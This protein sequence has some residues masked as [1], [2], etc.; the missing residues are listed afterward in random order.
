MSIRRGD[1]AF[2]KVKGVNFG[3]GAKSFEARV[4]SAADGR[5]HRAAPGQPDGTIGRD[6]HR[7][8]ARGAGRPGPPGPAKSA[9]PPGLHDLYLRFT[10]GSGHL[11]N[12]DWW[13]FHK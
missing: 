1:G 10:G 13:Q 3:A 11:F 12:F 6:L 8:R 5:E 2:I 7:C 9:V 4:A